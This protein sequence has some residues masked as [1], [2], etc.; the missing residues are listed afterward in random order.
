MKKIFFIL[1]IF[2]A[3]GAGN[4]SVYAMGSPQS[5]NPNGP[6]YVPPTKVKSP[7]P[8]TEKLPSTITHFA[9]KTK[10]FRFLTEAVTTRL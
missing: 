9:Q 1:T 3:L 7:V 10:L 8:P 4:V 6:N 5:T 2:L